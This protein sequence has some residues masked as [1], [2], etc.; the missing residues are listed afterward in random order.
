M[1]DNALWF[2]ILILE[3]SFN[4]PKISYLPAVI[5]RGIIRG[6]SIGWIFY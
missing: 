3:S 6:D 1:L 4:P 5:L 2:A